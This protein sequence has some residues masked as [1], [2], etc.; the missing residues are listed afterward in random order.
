MKVNVRKASGGVTATDD[1]EKCSDDP[2]PQLAAANRAQQSSGPR[3]V[4]IRSVTS[5]FR[6]MFVKRRESARKWRHDCSRLRWNVRQP[7]RKRS[8]ELI[9]SATVL[10][11]REVYNER[12]LHHEVQTTRWP[13]RRST[14]KVPA[15]DVGTVSQPLPQL[16]DIQ[17][18]L[19]SLPSDPMARSLTTQLGVALS[20]TAH[21]LLLSCPTKCSFC[22]NHNMEMLWCEYCHCY[23]CCRYEELERN[24]LRE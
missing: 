4:F 16:Q 19:D 11:Q 23:D 6:G 12:D 18:E 21:V 7:S 9:K 1:G 13:R 22:E 24:W 2:T 20:R 8:G 3:D 5:S 17:L 10:L 14:S 15:V